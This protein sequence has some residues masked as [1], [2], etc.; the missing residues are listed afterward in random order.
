MA[1]LNWTDQSVSDLVNIA[2]F[3]GKDSGK[4]AKLTIAKIRLSA[5]RVSDYPMLGRVVPEINLPE[6]RE[7]IVG[8]YRLIYFIV[9][10]NRIDI[11][12]VYHS[13]RI[14]NIKE[15]IKHKP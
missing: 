1:R 7:I 5:R 15:I 11:L 4:Y 8:N 6:I 10:Q 14:L 2:D 3:I 12:T 13:S 9:E